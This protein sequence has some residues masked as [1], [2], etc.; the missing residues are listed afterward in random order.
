MSLLLYNVYVLLSLHRTVV[1]QR[2]SSKKGKSEFQNNI[3]LKPTKHRAVPAEGE[4]GM[5]EMLE[6]RAARHKLLFRCSNEQRCTRC[7]HR[8]CSSCGDV[9]VANCGWNESLS[10]KPSENLG[11]TVAPHIPGRCLPDGGWY[12]CRWVACPADTFPPQ[13]TTRRHDGDGESPP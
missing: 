10:V 2:Q 9:V 6:C 11:A 4:K 1:W 8:T 5:P 3:C 7:S 12:G 13:S